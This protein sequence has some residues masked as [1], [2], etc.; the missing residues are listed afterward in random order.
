MSPTG[1]HA[2]GA[3]EPTALVVGSD[4]RPVR[5]AVRAGPTATSRPRAVPDPDDLYEGDQ[6]GHT[7][8]RSLVRAQ[9]GVTIGVLLP[10]AALVATYPLLSVLLPGVAD[11]AIGPVPLSLLV[12]GFGIYPPLVV[13][14]L[15]YVRR[16]RRVEDRFVELLH[17]E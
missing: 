17:E 5:V 4:G 16:A 13:L 11:A 6:Y 7:L 9:L 8:L 1:P 12:L 10:A 2:D 15:V 3:V 14:A